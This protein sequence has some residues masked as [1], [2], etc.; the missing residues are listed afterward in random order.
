M[1]RIHRANHVE[2]E[3]RWRTNWQGASLRF[4]R[5]DTDGDTTKSSERWL[6]TWKKKKKHKL[7]EICGC[8]LRAD[9]AIW[10]EEARGSSWLFRGK[11]DAK[12]GR[13]Q[14]TRNWHNNA[15]NVRVAG[16]AISRWMHRF[17]QV[18]VEEPHS[19]GNSMKGEEDGGQ[20]GQWKEA[21]IDPAQEKPHFQRYRKLKPLW[22]SPSS[23]FC[24][25]NN[26]F[27]LYQ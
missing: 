18:C 8:Y 6:T 5:G 21:L 19:S 11:R 25:K 3:T 12:R 14:S 7:R 9:I 13:P 15:V 22:H 23:T 10:S 16:Q 20:E 24:S 1:R 17:P 27:Y 4:A 2:R 26:I